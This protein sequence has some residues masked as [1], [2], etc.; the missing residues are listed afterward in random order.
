M[1]ISAK[2]MGIPYTNMVSYNKF[3]LIIWE[4]SAKYMGIP[5]TNMESHNKFSFNYTGNFSEIYGN[6]TNK[7]GV[8]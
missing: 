1:E 8:T 5:Q 2:Y 4:I 3:Y 6:S 7:Y